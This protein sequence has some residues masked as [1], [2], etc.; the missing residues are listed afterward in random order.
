[1]TGGP[2]IHRFAEDQ[3]HDHWAG[4]DFHRLGHPCLHAYAPGRPTHIILKPSH[5]ARDLLSLDSSQLIDSSHLATLTDVEKD[6]VTL[7]QLDLRETVMLQTNPL[8]WEDDGAAPWQ[9]LKAGT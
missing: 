6:G 9:H 2:K 3:C 4:T 7:T 8:Q 1:M 5:G